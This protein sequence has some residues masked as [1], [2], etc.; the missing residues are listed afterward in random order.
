MVFHTT[1]LRCFRN[2]FQSPHEELLPLA[3]SAGTDVCPAKRLWQ[4]AQREITSV[5]HSF[6][7]PK[8]PLM[9]Q[10]S[11]RYSVMVSALSVLVRQES[12]PRTA[13]FMWPY[14]RYNILTNTTDWTIQFVFKSC[15]F[16]YMYIFV[17]YIHFPDWH[18]SNRWRFLTSVQCVIPF[19]QYRTCSK[20]DL[21]GKTPRSSQTYHLLPGILQ[22]S[23]FSAKNTGPNAGGSQHSKSL[24]SQ[25]RL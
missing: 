2:P 4:A 24:S 7:V 18:R 13:E 11:H 5:P 21:V 6:D 17:Y 22:D 15:V 25:K 12:L 20:A 23:K 1:A 8:K 14:W 19:S 10:I 16:V 9:T 3:L